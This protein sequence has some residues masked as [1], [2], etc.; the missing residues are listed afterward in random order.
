MK[1]RLVAYEGLRFIFIIF[2][3]LLNKFLVKPA[4]NYL[5]AKITKIK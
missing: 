3:V 2:S 1:N 5:L 4:T